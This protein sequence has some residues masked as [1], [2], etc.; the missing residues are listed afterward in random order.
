MKRR[1]SLDRSEKAIEAGIDAYVPVE[2]EKRGRIEG[3]LE[4][5]RKTKN[6]NIRISEYDLASLKRKAEEEGMPYQTL[7]ASILH[8]YVRD[9]LVDEKDVAKSLQL[10]TSRS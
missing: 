7:V 1:L 6:I 3:I 8:K 10:L 9:R 4:R 5:G 2:G